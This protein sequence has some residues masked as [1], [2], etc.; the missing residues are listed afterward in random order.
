MAITAILGKGI[1]GRQILAKSTTHYEETASGGVECG[2]NVVVGAQF[3]VDSSGGVECGSE[4]HWGEVAEGGIE[5]GGAAEVAAHYVHNASGGVEVQGGPV[6]YVHNASGGV[7]VCGHRYLK[8]Q[9]ITVSGGN[10]TIL[11]FP[12]LVG[13]DCAV[14]QEDYVF[15][16]P[17]NAPYG[18]PVPFDVV[19]TRPGH[20]TVA[21]K[22]T[23]SGSDQSFLIQYGNR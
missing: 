22:T 18:P 3:V 21:I 13:I 2:G 23:L 1:F 7:E 10:S 5:A 12:V 11:A 16:T 8:T 6:N 14:G 20:F 19:A 15:V 4:N 9:K 17:A